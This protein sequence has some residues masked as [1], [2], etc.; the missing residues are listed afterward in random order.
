MQSWKKTSKTCRATFPNT[1]KKWNGVDPINPAV[2]KM[3]EERMTAML[4]KKKTILD[5][6][7]ALRSIVGDRSREAHNHEQKIT[8]FQE[9]LKALK[10]RQENAVLKEK[11]EQQ[12]EEERHI[13]RKAEIELL[14]AKLRERLSEE[15]KQAEE[16]LKQEED[17]HKL[18]TQ[19][20]DQAFIKEAGPSVAAAAGFAATGNAGCS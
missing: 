20:L 12:E 17:K 8:K 15:I 2:I 11:E 13:H 16:K 14:H 18:R 1:K 9:D 5:N 6:T 10:Q 4:K 7:P 3:M 19:E